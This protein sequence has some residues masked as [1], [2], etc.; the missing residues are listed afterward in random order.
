MVKDAAGRSDTENNKTL[1][2]T[3]NINTLNHNHSRKLKEILLCQSL[4]V[5]ISDFAVRASGELLSQSKEVG[6]FCSR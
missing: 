1:A 3:H 6:K 4:Q 2:F 5:G